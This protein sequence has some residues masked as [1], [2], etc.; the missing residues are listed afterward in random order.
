MPSVS[1]LGISSTRIIRTVGAVTQST[2]N[3]NEMPIFGPKTGACVVV[4]WGGANMWFTFA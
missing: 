4:V 2:M 1:E 3:P